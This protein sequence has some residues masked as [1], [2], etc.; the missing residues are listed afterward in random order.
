MY[1]TQSQGNDALCFVQVFMHGV[2]YVL[3]HD[4]Q[5][6]TN[7]LT[8]CLDDTNADCAENKPNT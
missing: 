4:A 5:S 3:V 7:G 6:A 2:P 8:Q 1:F